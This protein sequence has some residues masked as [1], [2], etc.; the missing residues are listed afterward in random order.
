MAATTSNI[1][2]GLSSALASLGTANP[3]ALQLLGNHL[4]QAGETTALSVLA[5]MQASPAT[6]SS[7]VGELAGIANLPPTVLPTVNAAIAALAAGDTSGFRI[8][9][10][11]AQTAL[12]TAVTSTSV[13][14]GLFAL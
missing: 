2:S 9:L 10:T 6:A 14:G 7:L 8:Q 1:L 13:L 12:I 3:G 11:A 4:S 5:S